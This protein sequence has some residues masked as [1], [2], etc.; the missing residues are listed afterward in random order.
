MIT[1]AVMKHHEQKQLGGRFISLTVHH[2][3]QL[4]QECQ[5]EGCR[6]QLEELL[7]CLL[8]WLVQLTFL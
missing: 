8:L 3:K 6:G 2:Q 4:G 5:H 7:T 1:I